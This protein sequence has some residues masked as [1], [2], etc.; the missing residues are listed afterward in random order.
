M[1]TVNEGDVEIK[2]NAIILMAEVTTL[3]DVVTSAIGEEL[4][5]PQR[6]IIDLVLEAM[7]YSKL[8]KAGMTEQEAFGVLGKTMIS[9]EN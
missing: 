6:E 4:D 9:S 8:R 3:L 7:Q 2:G 1:I 5:K